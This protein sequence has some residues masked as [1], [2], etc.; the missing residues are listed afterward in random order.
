MKRFVQHCRP[1]GALIARL[2]GIACLILS[3]GVASLGQV[4][5]ATVV[6]T[7]KDSSDAV[8]PG[9]QIV[10]KNLATG[11]V[12][13]AVSA[14]DGA[15]VIPDVPPGHYSITYTHEGFKASVIRDIE[16]LVAQRA[17][18]DAKLEVGEV[19]SSI[20]V[21]ETSS[22]IESSSSDVVQVVNTVT[23]EH[24]PLNGRSF[25]Q[26]TSLTPGVTYTPGGQGTHTGGSSIRSSAVAVNINGGPA[27]QTGWSLDG[28]WITEMQSGGTLI[29]PDV[30]A[31]QEFNVQ[32][33]GLPPE[34][35][36]TANLVNVSIKSGS[37]QFH[38][39]AFE[40][41]RNTVLDAR[42]Y[43]YLPPAGSTQ[44]RP[45]L[46]RN[47]Y[48]GT[49]GG[50]IVKNRTF[51]FTDIEKTDLA[52][53]TDFSNVVPAPEQHN[54]DF[55]A[56]LSLPTPIKLRDPATG[57]AFPNNQIQNYI[58]PQ[59][60]FFARYMPPPNQL[61]G[62]TYYNTVSAKLLQH[63]I[64]ADAK[65]DHQ[66][67]DN[68]HIFG[69]YSIINNGEQDPNPFTTLGS[70]SLYSRGQ[71]ATAAA[72]H[73][74]GSNW[75]TEARMSY[76]RSVFIFGGILQGTNI[77]HEAGIQ[78]FDNT[79]SVYGFPQIT[80]SGYAGYNGSPS[81]Q[82]PKSNQHRNFQ[83]AL[84]TTWSHGKHNAKVGGDLLHERAS[85]YNG[86]RAVGVFN[87][88]G[89][90]SGNA[91]ADM[92]LGYPDSVTRDYYKELNGDVGY[93][94]DLFAQ[95]SY[96]ATDKLTLNYGFRVERNT[97]Y[98]GINGQKSAF[99][100]TTGK[101]IIPSNI[102]PNAQPLTPTLVPLFSDRIVYTGA[103]Q[104]PNSIQPAEWDVVPRFGFAYAATRNTVLRGGYGIYQLFTDLG[105]INNEVATVPFV[106]A[107]TISNDR[108]PAK[109]T[110]TWGDYFLGQPNVAPNPKPGSACA[111]GFVANTC[112]TPDMTANEV[113]SKNQY[114][115]Q[116]TTGVQHQF[117]NAVSLDV[118]YIGTKTTHLQK[119]PSINDPL[120]GPGAIQSRRPYPQ[121]G[122]ITYNTFSG[123]A[124]YNALQAK[125]ETR[126]FEGLTLL[127]SY[128]YSRCLDSATGF[129][130]A[131]QPHA[132]AV[133]D[134]DFPQDFTGSFNYAL[135]FGPGQRWSVGNH[136]GNGIFGNFQLAGVVTARNGA[137]FTPTISTDR[138]N[139]GVGGQWPNRVGNPKVIGS[140]SC[141][142]YVSANTS[143][144]AIAPRQ[145][146]A[147]VMP[148]QYTYGNGGRNVLRAGNLVELD[149]TL[150][151]Q[152][153]FLESRTLELRFEGF[154]VL[155]HPSFAAPTTTINTG[156]GGQVSST[157]N[158]SR[159]LQASA[160]LFF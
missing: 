105:T 8:L 11:I 119:V 134:Y 129:T 60:A 158:S 115:Q 32:S 29:Q 38:G 20:T 135:P 79:T 149:L 15:F 52:S 19:T 50:P 126:Q 21:N 64:R 94:F 130:A 59:G 31:L 28:A 140:P 131:Y 66:I 121:W 61:R 114:V 97:F 65:V 23:I 86:S 138:A 75:I 37:N 142:F 80:L 151:K 39:S 139:T 152:I 13:H 88:T 25:W 98:E 93:Y 42:N 89:V 22:L 27:N 127:G 6:G 106:A 46:R 47:Q 17:V 95:D 91:F 109:P 154:N 103:L 157:I 57:Q 62:N 85:F 155:N 90:Y 102:L 14:D 73:N 54:G 123:Y 84:D 146:V 18:F 111:F 26:L 7:T 53:G 143:C 122:V 24:A 69:R 70:F 76:Y 12:F 144:A 156:S 2:A 159:I 34:Y 56:L 113:K 87:F 120:P 96:R 44:T 137:P 10:L 48:G 51:F 107:V 1:G 58:S 49:L 100:A 124:N 16:L 118:T 141:W 132:Y 45:L 63:I 153:K 81:D 104:L 5:N 147:F 78:G 116:W 136:V 77:D 128:T 101:L 148:A 92:L 67:N 160:K 108:A 74:W 9:A 150:L 33:A 110:R 35:G 72:I 112:A 41:F 43:F 71:S 145:Q 55:S 30:D 82:R 99:D 4:T 3:G 68:N 36:R 133:C 83:Y 117:G 125:L 40:F